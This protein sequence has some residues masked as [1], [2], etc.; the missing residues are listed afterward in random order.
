MMIAVAALAP[1]SNRRLDV[2][3]GKT[4]IVSPHS[5]HSLFKG[6]FVRK[7]VFARQLG[8]LTITRGVTIR[9]FVEN[10]TRFGPREKPEVGST[11]CP[12]QL[13]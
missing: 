4:R 3:P 11:G 8:H 10:N 7:K 12:L 9:T 1:T 2:E 5:V 6:L 13:T